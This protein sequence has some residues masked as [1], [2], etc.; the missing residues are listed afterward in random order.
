V[1]AW[2][3]IED[4][5][6]FAVAS[7]P[8]TQSQVGRLNKYS[9]EAIL[10]KAYLF[11]HKNAEAKP[12]LADIINSGKYGL[13]KYHENFDIINKNN[14]ESIFAAQ[15]SVNDG[16]NGDNGNWGDVLNFPYGGSPGT[17]C[18]FNQPTQYL[19]NHF[20]TDA[21]TGLPDLD[22]FASTDIPSDMGKL[23][24]DA[25]TPYAG[26]VDSRL[27]WTVGRRGLPFLDWGI[28]PGNDWIRAQSDGG[29]YD[30]V[31]NVYPNSLLGK[32]T[33]A[34]FW[35]SGVTA[36]NVNLIRYADVLLL[37]AEIE[38]EIGS[39]EQARAYVNL[40]RARAADPAG[41]PKTYLNNTDP[42]G[43]FSNTP[44]ANYKVGQYLTVWIDQAL[45]RKAVRFERELELGMEGHR[46]FDLVRW[47]IA[48]TEIPNYFLHE[49]TLTSYLGNGTF[50]AGVNE[51][52]PIPQDEIDKSGGKLVQNPGY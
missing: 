14:K 5:L 31:K 33:D 50:V 42:Q 3:K 21:T 46:F 30:P 4:D 18:G 17:C 20:K 28:N 7:L 27:D 15:S 6:K 51:Y 19:V 35:S 49:K 23:S 2:P 16:A 13:G 8:A 29:P 22:N 34:S 1:D 38:V 37:A 44:A 39:L 48:K 47:D 12:L 26:T 10:A 52:F 11:E 24:T 41:W 43:G 25:F 9:A 40:V 32:L 45:A 36:I